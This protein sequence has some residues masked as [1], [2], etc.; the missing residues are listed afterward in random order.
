LWDKLIHTPVA[1]VQYIFS[2]IP[3][4]LAV[5]VFSGFGACVGRVP[6]RR[7]AVDAGVEEEIEKKRSK[8]R[9]ARRAVRLLSLSL[10]FGSH[11]KYFDH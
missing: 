7:R 11:I 5:V 10:P 3:S 6:P 1:L 8:G 4:F 2:I 9:A